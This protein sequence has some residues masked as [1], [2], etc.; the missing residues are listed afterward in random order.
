MRESAGVASVA[1]R[2]ASREVEEVQPRRLDVDAGFLVTHRLALADW[3][4]AIDCLRSAEA[5]GG[6]V[7][8]EIGAP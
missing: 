4:R 8:L 6:K 3:A 1:D 5:P 2:G 7:L